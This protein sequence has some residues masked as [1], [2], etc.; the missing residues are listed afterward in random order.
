LK[1]EESDSCLLSALATQPQFGELLLARMVAK[2]ITIDPIYFEYKI[3]SDTHPE[4][5]EL[6]F[7]WYCHA[8]T[9]YGVRPSR[10]MNNTV[11]FAFLKANKFNRAREVFHWMKVEELDL[12]GIHLNFARY[13]ILLT[14]FP[15]DLKDLRISKWMRP[16]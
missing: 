16:Y 2:S 5:P 6:F 7:A 10:L 14:T 15:H 11:T 4:D 3:E 8:V 1:L 12:G 13:R 9:K